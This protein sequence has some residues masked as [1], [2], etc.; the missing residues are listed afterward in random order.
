[1]FCPGNGSLFM[2]K[3]ILFFGVLFALLASPV[4]AAT[5]QELQTIANWDRAMMNLKFNAALIGATS[6]P[7]ALRTPATSFGNLTLAPT[8]PSS[9]ELVLRSKGNLR[10]AGSPL[11]I[12]VEAKLV[13]PSLLGALGRFAGKVLPFL[14][15]GV[16]LYDLA[17]EL[18]FEASNDPAGGPATFKK[19]EPGDQLCSWSSNNTTNTATSCDP[20]LACM[21]EAGYS[22][23][24]QPPIKIGGTVGV[25]GLK[26]TCNWIREITLTSITVTEPRTVQA[27]LQEFLD[28]V[29]ASSAAMNG[30]KMANLIR[31]IIASGE[32]I[33]T[34][35]PT[36]SG[37]AS[38]PGPTSTTQNP[39]G[40]TTTTTTTNNYSYAG[41]QITHSTTSTT[42]TCVGV[43]SCSQSTTT[44]SGGSGGADPE[45][46]TAEDTEFE[47]LPQLYTPKYPNGLAGVWADKKAG[48]SSTP[49]ANLTSQLMPSL[50]TSGTCPSW[51][52]PLD[53]GAWNF[54]EYDV[55]PPCWIWD[56]AKAIVIL[57]ALLL[58]R[59]LVFGG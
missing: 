11:V 58:A 38:T 42:N 55:A 39:D 32:P 59:A 5:P 10:V 28:A 2:K 24:M 45:P 43:G 44:T 22:A 9:T 18:N 17:E 21:G 37:P 29:A 12:D 57:S 56:F 8:I 34:E 54:G 27:T 13:K 25:V 52:L 51:M 3:I 16:A 19:E 30:A 33:A 40:S 36:V 6:S 23:S 48:M 35:S 7:I 20:S 26:Y 47:P 31:D 53:L 14:S 1:M 4:F 41:D 50:S 15:T 49:L 46:V